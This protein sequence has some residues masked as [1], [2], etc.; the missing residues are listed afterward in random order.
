[1]KLLSDHPSRPLTHARVSLHNLLILFWFAAF[2][3]LH[4]FI[5]GLYFIPEKIGISSSAE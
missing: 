4:A 2:S 1:M 3:F 5:T